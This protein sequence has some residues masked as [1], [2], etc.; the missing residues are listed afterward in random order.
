LWSQPFERDFSNILTLQ[1][2][3]AQA[4]VENVRVNVSQDERQR[5]GRSQKT[6]NPQAYELYLRARQEMTRLPSNPT[7]SLWDSSM[8]KLQKAIDI[9]PDNALYYAALASG[10]GWA[11]AWTLVPTAEL[12]PKIKV[13]AEKA[14]RL[15]P[16]LAESQLAAAVADMFQY[17]FKSVQL[18]TSR[19]LA[20]SPGSFSAHMARA[21]LLVSTGRLEEALVNYRRARELD[22]V[23]F[24]ETGFGLG[25][26]YFMMRRYDD[27]IATFRELM[28][29][30]P[31]SDVAHAFLAMAFSMKGMHAEALAH[32]DSTHYWGDMNRPLLL[33]KAGKRALAI[34]VFERD[35]SKINAYT[36]AS[37]YALIGEKDSAFQWLQRAY[38]DRGDIV[39]WLQNDPFLDT[40][41]DDPRYREL[42]KKMNLLD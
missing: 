9:E 26:I 12:F 7:K 2:E 24:K 14:L 32:N 37:F 42:L 23:Q 40:L 33:A 25:F 35:R 15:D 31:K 28:R 22:P 17:N 13:A 41:R 18:R 11:A 8:A 19:A 6:V 29:E 16:D 21:E 5:L 27:A 39:L 1:S 34:R 20:L 4:I 36:K 38:Q 10:Y 3:L 30:I